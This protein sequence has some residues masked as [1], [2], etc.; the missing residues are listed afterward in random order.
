MKKITFAVIISL[1]LV[2]AIV[3]TGFAA[4]PGTGWWSAL[5]IQNISTTPGSVSMEAYDMGTGAPIASDLF[6]F[7]PAKALVYDPGL[8]PDY[9]AGPVIG[10]Q[11]SLPGGF[12]G[13]VVISASVPS[14]SVSQLANYSNGGVG[15]AGKASAMYPGVS[16]EMLAQELYAPTI[17][18]NYSGATTTMYIQAAGAEAEVTVAYTMADGGYYEVT[19]TIAANRSFMFDPAGAGIPSTGCG[20]DTMT[21]PCYGSAIVTASAPVAGVLV[22]HAHAGSP[23]TFVQAIRLST[24]QDKSE[25]I[26][27]PSVKNN[28]CGSSGCGVAGAAVQNADDEAANVTITL[29]VTKLGNNAPSGVSKGDVYTDSATIPAGENYNFSKWNNNLGGLP[30]GTMAAAVIECTNGQLLIGSSND[31][32]TQSGFPGQA[33]VKYSAFPDALATELAFAPKI[34][35]FSGIFT[36]GATVQNVGDSSDYIIIEYHELGTGE[37]CA[38]VTKDPVPPGGAAETNWVSVNGANQFDILGGDCGSF[39]WLSGKQFSV[40]AYSDAGEDIVI[41]V[42]ENTPGGT[43]D[44]SRYEGVNVAPVP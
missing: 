6:D 23:A 8:T 25:I 5:A 28:F 39:G 4:L 7:D 27:V 43:H 19:E 22:E 24:P 10:F 2:L 37:M 11:S 36:G 12:E 34:K 17:K 44:I 30:N 32:K 21:S 31:A 18:H 14:A 42:T 3:G 41:M 20:Y 16:S 38:M 13:S 33:K 9:P 1:L 26:Y 40:V 29:T 15:G 35:E